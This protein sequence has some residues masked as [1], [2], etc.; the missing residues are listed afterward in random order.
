[1]NIKVLLN[2]SV[3]GKCV[4]WEMCPAL[5]KFLGN[6][7]LP[8]RIYTLSQDQ[9]SA[10]NINHCTT[11]TLPEITM[12][13]VY[14]PSIHHFNKSR[15]SAKAVIAEDWLDCMKFLLY[16]LQIWEV[17]KIGLD[18]ALDYGMNFGLDEYLFKSMNLCSH[19]GIYAWYWL[20]LLVLCDFYK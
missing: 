11:C 1:M 8:D 4:H 5:Y 20:C 16:T 15:K 7:V 9:M 6:S 10:C 19:H 3:R 13:G 17:I 2:L 18:F 14:Q 12:Y